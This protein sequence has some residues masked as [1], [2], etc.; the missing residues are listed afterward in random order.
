MV[1]NLVKQ[2][3]ESGGSITP[4][5][6]DSSETNGTGLMNPSIYIDNDEIILNLRHVNYTLY[7]CEGEQLFINRWGPLAYLNPENDIKLRTTNFLCKLDKNLNIKSHKKMD[8]SK[9]DVEPLWEF[10]GL[11]DVRPVRWDDKLYACGVRRDTTTNGVGRMEL[12]EISLNKEISRNRIEPPND[13]NSYCEKNWM[14]IIDMPFHFVKWSN[15]TEVVKVDVESGTSQTVVLKNQIGDLNNLRGGSHVIPYKGKR[16]C[17]VHEVF[18]SKNK[19]DQRDAKYTHRFIVW[20]RNWN[21]EHISKPFNFMSGEIEFCCGLAQQGDDLLISFGFQDNAAFILKMGTKFFESF[22]E[23]GDFSWGEISENQWFLET[24]NNE[25]FVEDSYQKFFSVEKNDVVVDIG[26]SVGPF[27]YKILSKDPKHIYCLEPQKQLFETLKLNLSKE[28]ITLINKGISNIDGE[29]I[30][31]GL[32]DKDYTQT[33]EKEGIADG[34]RF[35]TFL[36]NHNISKIDFLKLDCE[37]GEYD[38]FTPQN[39]DFIFK[40]VSK[41]AGEF[42]LIDELKSKFRIFRDIYLSRY[43]NFQIYSMDGVDIKWDIWN[44]HF[45]EYYSEVMIYIDNRKEKKNYWKTASHPTLEITTSIPTKGCA[46]NCAFC[47]QLTLLNVYNSDKTMTLENFKLIVDKV[48]KEIRITFSGFTEPWLNRNTTDMLL[49]AH[50]QGHPVSVFTTGIGMTVEDVRRIKNIPFCKG[51]NGGFCLHLPDEERIAKHP[52]SKT[53]IE[54]LEYIKS[55]QYEINGFYLMSMGEVLED[56]KYIFPTAH[57]PEM[58]SRA[59]NLL[60]EAI[61]KPELD[62]IKHRF[63]S[64]D[65]GDYSN[66]TCGCDEKLYHNVV[67]PN[68]DV[69]LCCMDYGLKQILGNIYREEYDDIIPMPLSCFSLCRLCENGVDPKKCK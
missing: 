22:V 31:R 7:H 17:I 66:R 12:S 4:I 2:V 42:H 62:K 9:F 38:I 6:I 60:G 36:K 59:G 20:D 56:I 5:I 46:V 64:I 57:T 51:P 55:V 10:V 48:P 29:F 27:S 47:P 19:L 1:E 49:Y 61:I 45:I 52:M 15:A 50:E 40:N 26:A 23:M 69:S 43:K 30:T 13:P 63:K 3:I 8:M 54:V 34:I 44:D 67:L 28:N 37:G 21:I 32:Y 53:Y 35:D 39:F 58:W 25:I 41:I 11:E 65:H 24:L 68:G 14:P 16:I 18:M 33:W